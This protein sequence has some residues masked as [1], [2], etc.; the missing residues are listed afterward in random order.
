MTLSRQTKATSVFDTLCHIQTDYQFI[1]FVSFFALK[2]ASVN[3]KREAAMG[4]TAE[5]GPE[6]GIEY[7]LRDV[8]GKKIFDNLP[9]GL[10]EKITKILQDS[11]I[12]TAKWRKLTIK[13]LSDDTFQVRV[14]KKTSFHVTKKPQEGSEGGPIAGAEQ[15]AS[16]RETFCERGFLSSMHHFWKSVVR[17]FYPKTFSSPGDLRRKPLKAIREDY[18]SLVQAIRIG[19]SWVPSSSDFAGRTKSL[20]AHGEVIERAVCSRHPS[21]ALHALAEE[22]GRAIARDIEYRLDRSF[23]LG[24]LNADGVLQPIVVRFIHEGDR[25][26]LEMFNDTS[27]AGEKV[28]PT[29]RWE[30]K[31]KPSNDDIQKILTTLFDQLVPPSIVKESPSLRLGSKGFGT[32]VTTVT[33]DQLKE[34]RIQEKETK[35]EK[36]SVVPERRLPEYAGVGYGA[37]ID[38]VGRCS[39]SWTKQEVPEV[40]SRPET[41]PSRVSK[42]FEYLMGD[43]KP[44]LTSNQRLELLLMMTVEWA[45]RELSRISPTLSDRE[46]LQRYEAVIAMV[47]HTGDKLARALTGAEPSPARYPERLQR[48]MTS[49]RSIAE[50]LRERISIQE[51]EL[52]GEFASKP[53]ATA[54]PFTAPKVQPAAVQGAL[55]GGPAEAAKV[56]P[57]FSVGWST[58]LEEL[59]RV[60]S[61]AQRARHLAAYARVQAGVLLSR[62]KEPRFTVDDIFSSSNTMKDFVEAVV[63]QLNKDDRL[64]S[65]LEAQDVRGISPNVVCLILTQMVLYPHL[66][67]YCPEISDQGVGKLVSVFRKMCDPTMVVAG[68]QR[69]LFE[70]INALLHLRH[71]VSPGMVHELEETRWQ[72]PL[73]EQNP[74]ARLLAQD[75]APLNAVFPQGKAAF[76]VADDCSMPLQVVKTMAALTTQCTQLMEVAR[77]ESNLSVRKALLQE[78]QD[79]ALLIAQLAPPPGTEEAFGEVSVWSQLDAEH[80]KQAATTIHELQK[81]IWESQM[82]LA[83]SDISGRA[84]FLLVKSRAIRF[85]L[86]RADAAAERKKYEAFLVS[87]REGERDLSSVEP[88]F[89]GLINARVNW[90]QQQP[91]FPAVWKAFVD[92]LPQESPLRQ[93]AEAIDIDLLVLDTLTIDIAA[94]NSVLSQDVTTQISGEASLERDLTSV[95]QFCF[96][97]FGKKTN[98]ISPLFVSDWAKVRLPIDFLTPTTMNVQ[99]EQGKALYDQLRSEWIMARTCDDPDF[100]LFDEHPTL[101]VG[102]FS[103]NPELLLKQQAVC[104]LPPDQQHE[105]FWISGDRGEELATIHPHGHPELTYRPSSDESPTEED[106]KKIRERVLPLTVV[107]Q[108][109]VTMIPDVRT[110]GSDSRYL[111]YAVEESLSQQSKGVRRV[112]TG[113]LQSLYMMRRKPKDPEEQDWRTS[114]APESAVQALL[115][116][117]SPAH[118]Y[119][120]EDPRVQLFVEETL[121]GPFLLQQAIVECPGEIVHAVEMIAASYARAVREHCFAAALLLEV[122][123]RKLRS[124]V[125]FAR[126]SLQDQGFFSGVI[127]SSPSYAV[128][129]G[130]A[131]RN[132][133]HYAPLLLKGCLTG[134]EEDVNP[135]M[136]LQ[137]LVHEMSAVQQCLERVETVVGSLDATVIEAFFTEERG[138]PAIDGITDLAARRDAYALALD[139]YRLRG[140][141]LR[142][143][144]LGRILRGYQLLCDATIPGGGTE[145]A[146][147]I[148][149]W[150]RQT[151]LPHVLALPEA[152]QAQFLTDVVGQALARRTPPGSIDKGVRWTK[153]SDIPA[154]FSA[155]LPTGGSVSINLTTMDVEDR[156][157]TS[158]LSA[159][160]PVP[161]EW[162][163]LVDVQKALKVPSVTA[164]VVRRGDESTYTWASEGQEFSLSG[165]P[166]NITITRTVLLKTAEGAYEP[167]TLTYVPPPACPGGSQAAAL[168]AENGLWSDDEGRK[169]LFPH[170]IKHHG[171]QLEEVFRVDVD[172]TKSTLSIRTWDD[173][174]VSCSETLD[175]LSPVPA[176]RS[177]DLIVLLD[178]QHKRPAELRVKGSTLCF[179]RRGQQWE[180]LLRGNTVGVLRAPPA[181]LRSV[182]EH[183]FGNNWS[184]YVIPVQRTDGTFEFVMIPYPPVRTSEG[185]L[186]VVRGG[187]ESLPAAE[188]VRIGADGTVYGSV[189]AKVYMAHRLLYQAEGEKV[190]DA[191]RDLYLTAQTLIDSM[192]SDRPPSDKDQLD[193]VSRIFS[194]VRQ[195]FPLSSRFLQSPAGL[196]MNL[197]LLLAVDRLQEM[198]REALQPSP[199]ERFA[200]LDRMAQMYEAYCVLKSSG[201]VSAFTTKKV[202]ASVFLLTEEEMAQLSGVGDQLLRDLSTP[203]KMAEFFG[204]QG[205]PAVE[206]PMPFVDHADPDFLLT[207]LRVSQPTNET[208]QI[209]TVTSP[210]PLYDLLERFWSYVRSI[211]RDGVSVDELSFLFIPSILPAAHS[212]EEAAFHRKLDLQARQFLLSLAQLHALRRQIPAQIREQVQ[213]VRAASSGLTATEEQGASSPLDQLQGLKGNLSESAQRMQRSLA[214]L[215]F[216]VCEPWEEVARGQLERNELSEEELKKAFDKDGVFDTAL[217]KAERR[218]LDIQ[219][220][221]AMLERDFQALTTRVGGII[222]AH[223]AIDQALAAQGADETVLQQRRENKAR[224]FEEIRMAEREIFGFIRPLSYHPAGQPDRFKE[225]EIRF[226]E[227]GGTFENLSQQIK[228]HAKEAKNAVKEFLKGDISKK[229]NALRSQISEKKEKSENFV[230]DVRK[231]EIEIFAMISPLSFSVQGPYIPFKKDLLLLQASGESFLQGLNSLLLSGETFLSEIERKVQEF[232]KECA[233]LEAA[234]REVQEELSTVEAGPRVEER[235]SEAEKTIRKYRDQIEKIKK[236][237]QA[238]VDEVAENPVTADLLPRSF[239][240]KTGPGSWRT[241]LDGLTPLRDKVDSLVKSISASLVPLED[242]IRIDSQA[243]QFDQLS[244]NAA[245]CT[246]LPR[247]TLSFPDD[248][249]MI[250]VLCELFEKMASDSAFAQNIQSIARYV[251][252]KLGLIKGP[253]LLALLY[254]LQRDGMVDRLTAYIPLLVA[255]ACIPSIVPSVPPLS[256]ARRSAPLPSAALDQMAKSPAALRLLTSDQQQKLAAV[257]SQG[258]MQQQAAALQMISHALGMS[259]AQAAAQ[260]ELGKQCERAER[261]YLTIAARKE[262]EKR[263]EGSFP[264][265]IRRSTPFK[266]PFFSTYYRPPGVF[267]ADVDSLCQKVQNQPAAWDGVDSGQWILTSTYTETPDWLRQSLANKRLPDCFEASSDMLPYAL[268]FRRLAQDCTFQEAILRC[269]NV[270]EVLHTIKEFASTEQAADQAHQSLVVGLRSTILPDDQASLYRQDLDQSLSSL[271]KN[272]PLPYTTVVDPLKLEAMA[273]GIEKEIGERRQSIQRQRETIVRQVRSMPLAELPREIQ[274]VRLRQ[275]SDDQ[276]L[277]ALCRHHRNR[278]FEEKWPALDTEISALEIDETRLKAMS[279]EPTCAQSS[280]RKLQAMSQERKEL[281]TQYDM[282]GLTSPQKADLMRRIAALETQAARESARLKDFL[283]RCQSTDVLETTLK[284]DKCASLR[285]HLR[286]IIYLQNRLGITLRENQLEALAEMVSSPSLLKQLRMGLGKTSVLLP[287]ALD[288]LGSEGF[289]PIGIV[290][291]AL[292]TTN[293]Q[294]MDE[295]TRAVFELSGSQFVFSRQSLARPFSFMSLHKFSQECASLLEALERGGYVL[296]TI[297]SKASIDNKIIEVERFRDDV[298]EQIKMV[299]DS[300]KEVPASMIQKLE[301]LEK[302]LGL[303]YR[304]KSTFELPT[305]RLVI[306]EAD[307]VA[308]AHYS[309]NAEVGSK[310]PLP[311]ILTSVVAEIF[312]IIQTSPEVEGLRSQIQTNNQFTLTS[313][314]VDEYLVAIGRRWL[315]NHKSELSELLQNEGNQDRLLGWLAGGPW[316]FTEGAEAILGSLAEELKVLRCALNSSLRA[317]LAL[318]V[319]LSTDFD[320]KATGAVGVPASQGVTTATTK[321]SDPL[322]QLCLTSMVALYKPQSESFLVSRAESVLSEIPETSQLGIKAKRAFT[323]LLKDHQEKKTTLGKGLEGLE[324]WKVFI[325]QQYVQQAAG[326]MCMYISDSQIAR[327]VQDTLRGCHV[328]GLTGTA[329]RNL[330]H[331]ITEEGMKGVSE[332]GRETT[333]EVVYRLVRSS[334]EQLQTPL[335]T[336]SL[337]PHTALEQCVDCARQDSG[338]R[339]LINQ[340]GIADASTEAE[341]IDA[342]QGGGRPIVYIDVT[343]GKRTTDK[344]T[345]RIHGVDK[346]LDEL[347]EDEKKEVRNNGFFYYHTPHVRGTH[348]DIPTG[349]R[350]VVMLSPTVN[351]NDRDQALYRARE[352]GEGHVV[353]CRISEK[354]EQDLREKLRR[355]PILADL[356]KVHHEQTLVDEGVEDLGAYRLYLNGILG[357]AADR[358][359]SQIQLQAALATAPGGVIGQEMFAQREVCR[360]CEPLFVHPG[361]SDTYLRKLDAQIDLGGEE[362]T[363]IHLRRLADGQIHKATT[364]L[365]R[366]QK[367][368][369]TG[370]TAFKTVIATVTNAIRQLEAE[371]QKIEERWRAIQPQLPARTSAMPQGQA[372]AETE[373]EAEEQQEVKAEVSAKTSVVGRKGGSGERI[374]QID[375]DIFDSIEAPLVLS[376]DGIPIH[377]GDRA[378]AQYTTPL[379][380]D[381]VQES[382]LIQKKLSLMSGETAKKMAIRIFVYK[383]AGRDHPSLCFMDC[384]EARNYGSFPVFDDENKLVNS[385]VV[386]LFIN[387]DGTISFKETATGGMVRGF[388]GQ[389]PEADMLLGLLCIGIS[390]FSDEQW[391]LIE[392]RWES[393]SSEENGPRQ[394]FQRLIENRY[395]REK[396][397]LLRTIASHTWRRPV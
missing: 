337:D 266:E 87:A 82:R 380:S 93:Q 159:P 372:A 222:D 104:L 304:I 164:R 102:F 231:A 48:I 193:A 108:L 387:D 150:V 125:E 116:L 260:L 183:H 276:L 345:V 347:T 34:L 135:V 331:V 75:P 153:H 60:S 225:I 127:S 215:R 379:W 351:A 274:E 74:T 67:P 283:S 267:E 250:K 152:E 311:P 263:E 338:Y 289:L 374:G 254:K 6:R 76:A 142:Q 137:P 51:H 391:G 245:A 213:M 109:E 278:E 365:L 103:A 271:E 359:K 54:L 229:M 145:R 181:P 313:A 220:S 155:Q 121:F 335:A 144:V 352:L 339:F 204:L 281:C 118:L 133:F 202:H 77:R 369:Y 69:E 38:A 272:N 148:K 376:L 91:D 371:K 185:S 49:C 329:T 19:Q 348:F 173:S 53:Q 52:S 234:I 26:F 156:R 163:E 324:P 11:G 79:K 370:T 295:T 149:R 187:E 397:A 124:L 256:P 306:D 354:Q 188:H 178:A 325:R 7:T 113:V 362:S 315:A 28:H 92:S 94:A 349:S 308:R 240:L 184:E 388:S 382:K 230:Q 30:F 1:F 143:P 318:K 18:S 57:L 9:E 68:D 141:D 70:M 333:A 242:A 197:R 167:C 166:P 270:R 37:V 96:R 261:S 130:G 81:L 98:S 97:D 136:S 248:P 171:D 112:D 162:M 147:T 42:W 228:A 364:L 218:L 16:V 378:I 8:R 358:A 236:E 24:F 100:T 307:Q 160:V 343:P 195:G 301:D 243:D 29:Q 2:S 239:Y 21:R 40:V 180:C 268:A 341:I 89:Q 64:T 257:A 128:M 105:R 83:R 120:L 319:G 71:G 107:S 342:L 214:A 90:K 264:D 389:L 126:S 269:T 172:S 385:S 249:E 203:K 259:E 302:A 326:Q 212:I 290:P 200:V 154:V 334:S 14:D 373:A 63:S 392:R 285:P 206:A 350:G 88:L 190:V 45:E 252:K 361:D 25:Y 43:R 287:F 15:W 176:L 368:P 56:D 221:P 366:L 151:V 101:G 355:P 61:P 119:D 85:A 196:A 95:Y 111:Q 13:K 247:P 189:A 356:L 59:K 298:V 210:L 62:L 390:T 39:S 294:E 327:P 244:Q 299:Q 27:E 241:I 99:G 165:S 146:D 41:T 275:G 123:L 44:P 233:R 106:Q 114:Y 235:R 55:A 300:G 186:E 157:S 393:L 84:R 132:V 158:A 237:R 4:G 31:Q 317:C 17:L 23:P 216:G 179:R 227:D 134:A 322:M 255:T 258:S 177:R 117:G 309:V 217:K 232:D 238:Y 357:A 312:A 201:A 211:E 396:P 182:L 316:P 279:K 303:L 381:S 292:F 170:G 395:G 33:A 360:L 20:V 50:A 282:A 328:I 344:K 246:A 161:K 80:R 73:S 288:I 122:V 194:L 139:A 377:P 175:Q 169:F 208:V 140:E 293:F 273:Q 32:L 284:T 115:F 174:V 168:L 286:K 262:T 65:L 332:A 5:I 367:S 223:A 198:N 323:A 346:L 336:Y 340:A 305:A 66:M 207:L 383:Q 47:T 353:E 296:T 384:S 321:F 251:M 310:K 386:S 110:N 320:M 253:K 78:V 129:T 363:Q 205:V 12:P 10:K 224:A 314:M 36:K 86:V 35:G 131:F 191:A 58:N 22:W 209:R 46:A 265:G 226:L 375:R 280:I 330:S 277:S 219:R 72:K 3:N 192:H 297:E 394:R 291:R 138:R 199:R